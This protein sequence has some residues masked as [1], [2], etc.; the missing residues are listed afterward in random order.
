MSVIG[1]ERLIE[2]IT[3]LRMARICARCGSGTT[4]GLSRSHSH[5]GT[6]RKIRPNLQMVRRDSKRLLLCARCIKRETKAANV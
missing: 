1:Y 2:Y 3:R 6:K 4:T 5:I